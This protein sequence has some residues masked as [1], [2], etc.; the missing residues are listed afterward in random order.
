MGQMTKYGEIDSSASALVSAPYTLWWTGLDTRV[1][2]VVI[3][4]LVSCFYGE[5]KKGKKREEIKFWGGE[6][7]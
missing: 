7:S 4:W 2:A 6:R 5:W 1:A 3:V